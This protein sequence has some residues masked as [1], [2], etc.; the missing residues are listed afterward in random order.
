MKGFNSGDSLNTRK[1]YKILTPEEK[2]L[3]EKILE[4]I[5][6]NN[7]I[8]TTSSPEE[9]TDHLINA[10]GFNKEEIYKLFK[11]INSISREWNLDDW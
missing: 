2:A 10:C 3:Y 11:K 6:K 7:H 1:L 4:D 8:Y 5:N 9:I